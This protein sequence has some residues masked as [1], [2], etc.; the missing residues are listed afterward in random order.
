[1]NIIDA[2]ESVIN[3]C[4]PTVAAE[5]QRCGITVVGGGA[6][7]PGLAKLMSEALRLK[8]RVPR[9]AQYATALGG[10]KLLSDPYLLEDILSHA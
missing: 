8:V 1:M 10:G 2:V 4:S 5:I 7:I 6:K 3:T 9:E